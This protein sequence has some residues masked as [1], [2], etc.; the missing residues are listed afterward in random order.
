MTHTLKQFMAE[1][2]AEIDTISVHD[3]LELQDNEETLFVD[4]RETVE[5]QKKGLIRGAVHAPRGFLEFM[6]D[7][8][9]PMH[10]EEFASDKRLIVYCA[11]G[12]RSTLAAHTLCKLG[13]QNVSSMAGGLAAWKEAGGAI[14]ESEA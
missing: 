3:A 6:A 11:T 12:G 8:Q 7:P 2:N 9:G 5:L 13:F 14:E 4:V 1:A 10:K